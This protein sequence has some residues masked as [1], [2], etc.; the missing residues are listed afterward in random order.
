MNNDLLFWFSAT[1]LGPLRILL[2]FLIFYIFYRLTAVK[3]SDQTG[4]E[5][6]VPRFV[7][8][9][10]AAII[11]SLFLTQINGF[12]T[13][14]ILMITSLFF[15]LSFLNLKRT[16]PLKPQLQKIYSRVILYVVI[17]FETNRSLVE[18]K[19]FR[20]RKPESAES[21]KTKF[22]QIGISLF[23]FAAIFVSRYYFLQYD[24]YLLS[25]SWY[26]DLDKVKSIGEQT[27]F[28]VVSDS[29][30]GY[31]II[32]LY[33][34][35][36]GLSDMLAL[37]NVGFMESALLA[38]II[39]WALYKI[40]HKHG[41]GLLAALVFGFG[42]SIIPLNIDSVLQHKSVFLS[43]TLALPL[44][45]FNMY[46]TSFR[47]KK[48]NYFVWSI[49]S[50][51]ALSFLNLFI[52]LGVLLPF[53]LICLAMNPSEK[54]AYNFRAL[55]A[56]G[57]SAVIII[58]TYFIVSF[59][60]QE[61]FV[62]VFMSKL[63]SFDYYTYTPNLILPFSELIW[64]YLIITLILGASAAFLIFKRSSRWRSISTILIF[65]IFLLTIYVADI[66]F[67]DDD[68]LLQLIS[69][70][71]PMVIGLFF[72][73]VYQPFYALIRQL[74]ASNLTE[75][76]LVFM[77][78]VGIFYVGKSKASITSEVFNA[79]K[80]V[81]HAYF[82]IENS[83]LP[84]SYAVVNTANNSR[85]SRG[86]HYFLSYGDFNASYLQKDEVFHRYRAE[87]EYLKTHPEIILPSSVFV[88]VPN[89][90]NADISEEVL[91][92]LQI[93]KR[94]GRELKPIYEGASVQVF[95]IVNIPKSSKINDLL[96]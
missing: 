86:G 69:V 21:R 67:L 54:R 27:W 45:I 28:S 88:F 64:Y 22:W 65:V 74:D 41:P 17:R 15:I 72:Y 43:M 49:I 7:M 71:L 80:D 70:F 96:L 18:R 16:K 55:I 34:K 61:S 79:K 51:L 62:D 48:S 83:R 29:M 26:E 38:V 40:T 3:I 32:S 84:Y 37:S 42:Y 11:G 76:S 14:L 59:F 93:L 39:Y 24:N 58:L 90:L 60:L 30:G 56:Y 82:E 95:E 9:F 44:M 57:I 73:L 78:A 91:K 12:D 46:P 53:I 35:I 33:A 6:F 50:I 47:Q 4:I 13:M 87:E 68:L 25:S 20:K 23:I 92:N 77:L 52:A 94:R 10:S 81:L 89:R 31:A 1:L 66:P 19:N 8:G 85:V 2:F 75:I 36:S 63:A 5:F